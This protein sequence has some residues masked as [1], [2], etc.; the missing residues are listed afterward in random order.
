MAYE[1]ET[2]EVILQ[3]MLDRVTLNYPDVDTREGSIV[4]NALAPAAMELAIMY[5]ELDNILCESF[6][7]TAS[8]E[9]LLMACSQ[10]GMDISNFEATAS[11]HKGAFNI[12]VPIG[13]VWNYGLYNYEV[14]EYLGVENNAYTYQLQ[15][16]TF[17][18]EPNL[19]TGDLI[20]IEQGFE[21]VT[22]VILSCLIEGK[23]ETSDDDIRN[24]YFEYVNASISDGNVGQYKN[25]CN[26]YD[27]VGNSKIFP[28]WNG[29]NTVKVSILSADNHV[30][31]EEL[32]DE[33]QEY[34]D[35]LDENGNPTG[36]G[37][38][39]APIGAFVTV[40]TA[41]ELPINV[42][43]TIKL[44]DGYNDTTLIDDALKEY[45]SEIA[46][47][48]SVV[49]YMSLG[50]KILDVDGV[51]FAS[52][53]LINGGTENIFLGDEEIPVLGTTTWTV[54]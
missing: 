33:F 38:G 25:W 35:P 53:L 6:V 2:Y 10:M 18:T 3:R 39:V 31:S 23:A 21:N 20:P 16:D 27:G 9:Y 5:T 14:T 36:M 46:Y 12:E 48:K 42:S 45:L 24:A 37:N 17:G 4:F 15:C 41:T 43:A 19:I 26:T 40:T 50:A 49:A 30:A 44:K 52:E 22:G 51:E 13:S 29:A 1:Y 11:V 34:L 28:L 54:S 8:R 47:D 32:I 7:T